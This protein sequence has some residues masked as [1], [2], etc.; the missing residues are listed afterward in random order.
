MGYKVNHKTISSWKIKL[1]S[2]FLPN[3]RVLLPRLDKEFRIDNT[4]SKELLG[5]EYRNDLKASM[6]D[7][8]YSM[9]E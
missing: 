8:V 6:H 4:S 3:I 1:A 9:M 7:M 5:M 2:Y